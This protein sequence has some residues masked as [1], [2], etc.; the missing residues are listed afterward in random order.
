[1]FVVGEAGGQHRDAD[2][3]SGRV[4]DGRPALGIGDV[5]SIGL[6]VARE[7]EA[8]AGL[9]ARHHLE[10]GDGLAGL[11]VGQRPA[12]RDASNHGHLDV[13]LVAPLR[14]LD[15]DLGVASG[16]SRC[17]GGTRSGRA[18]SPWPRRAG[19]ARF[20]T[21]RRGD[22]CRR[23]G[24][25]FSP[26]VT[27]VR[28]ELVVLEGGAELGTR[29]GL[30]CSSRTVP[31]AFQGSRSLRRREWG[32]RG[33]RR[34]GRRCVRCVLFV[35]DL[36]VGAIQPPPEA[37]GHGDEGEQAEVLS[38]VVRSRRVASGSCGV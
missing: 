35:G 19:G 21:T 11:D 16:C 38:L 15:L 12:D 30:S 2:L 28:I 26:G 27:M 13:R 37:Q 5:G 7:A 10:A 25:L 1:M 24:W 23:G 14:Q 36:V 4:L 17:R 22:R 8:G 9:V 32:R 29:D 20:P 3:A 6:A 31:W 18:G 33:P 34:R